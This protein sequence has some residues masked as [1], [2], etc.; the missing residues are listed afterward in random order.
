MR[1]SVMSTKAFRTLVDSIG[2]AR[3]TLSYSYI[4]LHGTLNIEYM[5]S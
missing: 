3:M 4:I 2:E 5:Q 1:S